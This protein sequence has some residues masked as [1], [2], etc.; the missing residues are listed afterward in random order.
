MIVKITEYSLNENTINF[1]VSDIPL[2]LLEI[3]NEKLEEETELNKKEAYL[4]LK[5]KYEKNLSPL[6]FQ[7]PE[8]KL[9]DYIASEEIEMEI[10]LS[11][12]LENFI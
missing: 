10:F 6:T 9:N 1:K 12:F 7:G 8:F 5:M 2:N 4:I 11:S 3:L